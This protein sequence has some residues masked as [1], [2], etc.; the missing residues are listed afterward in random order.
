MSETLIQTAQLTKRFRRLT[1]VDR[2]DLEVRRGDVF[3]FLGPN[4]AGKSTALRMMVGLIKPTAGSV[5]LFGHEV[6]RDRCRALGKVGA[7]IET[8]AFYKYLSGYE[9]LYI[10]ANSGARHSRR[11]IEEALD[12]VGLLGRARDHVKTYSQGMRQRL[13]IALAILG[14]PELILLDE[15]TNGLD[16]Q[17][18][19]E[20][21]DLIRRLSHEHGITVMLSSHLLHEVEQI[22][23][24]IAV[25][26]FGQV[27]LSGNVDELTAESGTVLVRCNRTEDACALANSLP[28]AA[29]DLEPGGDI[30]V[31]LSGGSSAELNALLV[32]QG[33]EV[34]A[35]IPNKTSLEELYLQLM[36]GDHGPADIL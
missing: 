4:G 26:N 30:R 24:R 18:M 17:G 28:W 10:L 20:I 32:R 36:G 8:P 9:N 19:K 6:W 23:T 25:I 16:P 33:F 11:E 1:A 2:L 35:L 5:R 22:C 7:M 3:G 21:R 34:S 29:A 27:V 15:P 14:T 13:A 31:R 12:I